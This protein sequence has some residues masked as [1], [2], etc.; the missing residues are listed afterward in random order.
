MRILLCHQNYPGQFKHLG[1]ALS[2]IKGNQVFG[3][4]EANNVKRLKG[5]PPGM[6]IV[7]YPQPKGAGDSTH[8]YLKQYESSVRRGQSVVKACL[9]LQQQHGFKPDVVYC[10]PGWGEGL[11]F[12]DIWPD[13]KVIGFFEFYYRTQ[14]A[15]FQFDK[16]FPVSL[17]DYLRVRV[18]NAHMLSSLEACDWGVSPTY[19]QWSVHPE[20]YR[21]QISVIF[22][23]VDTDD[24]A[25]RDTVRVQL[26]GGITI[27]KGDP[28]I[29]FVNRNLEP[30]RGYHV[31]LK[32]MVEIQKRHPT[33]QIVLVGG[34]QV[35]YGRPAP[36]GT[37]WKQLYLEKNGKDLDMSRVHFVGKLPY[38]HYKALIQVSAAHVYLTYPFVLS[39]SCIE[40]MSMG[41]LVIGSKT[42]P[43]EEAITHGKNGLL[44]DFFDHEA[45]AQT[46]VKVLNNPEKY[47]H[48]RDAA[49]KT[50]IDRYDLKSVCL[51]QQMKMINDLVNGRK[52]KTP[53]A[54]ELKRFE[55]V[56][57]KNK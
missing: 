37:T 8:H 20:Q 11:F 47:Q 55:D 6:T 43:V 5:A 31:F 27:K 49:R 38:T 16:E 18:K 42:S 34:D 24:L 14:G 35:S 2:A 23:G 36:T 19:W 54:A 51:P 48:L 50:A 26:P 32:A 33:A 45:L 9:Q 44:V 53:G 3:L 52:P 28:V 57:W 30:Y 41:A 40:A 13:A 25:P 10:H 46:V 15:D 17:D 39:W 21:K 12:K 4:G 56:I 29:T 7:G 22:D 1:P